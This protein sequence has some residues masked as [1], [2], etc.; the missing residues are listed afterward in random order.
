M[1]KW[2]DVLAL[3]SLSFIFIAAGTRS[4]GAGDIFTSHRTNIELQA[5]GG[6]SL[7]WGIS[8]VSSHYFTGEVKIS[9]D[10]YTKSYTF[11][12]P[13]HGSYGGMEDSALGEPVKWKADGK[14][15][16]NYYGNQE[17]NIAQFSITPSRL[18]DDEGVDLPRP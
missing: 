4:L 16:F 6:N 1:K 15:S 18:D 8:N 5:E 10:G 17:I 14:I 9:A 12:V 3:V 7:L 13:A 11:S 2:V